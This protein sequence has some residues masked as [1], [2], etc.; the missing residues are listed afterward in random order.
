MLVM[1]KGLYVIN[2]AYDPADGW[3]I[4]PGPGDEIE[5]RETDS[6]E[7]FR[8]GG[9]LVRLHAWCVGDHR[10]RPAFAAAKLLAA[11]LW[12]GH[13]QTA[14]EVT[15]R[16]LLA[17]NWALYIVSWRSR[18]WSARA[19]VTTFAAGPRSSRSA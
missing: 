12:T 19:R 17:L 16:V 15:L 7:L 1:Y 2:M 4:E 13:A 6:G 18:R 10:S 5:E 11:R 3:Q 9:D 14:L 8:D